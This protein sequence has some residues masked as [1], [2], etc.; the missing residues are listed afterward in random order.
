[1][2][3]FLCL[4]TACLISLF[5]A[6]QYT[7][8]L[9]GNNNNPEEPS[10]MINP[11]NPKY[12]VAG[13]NI[14]SAYYSSDTGR[15]WKG[16]QMS[17]SQGVYGDPVIICDTAGHFYFMHLSDPPGTPWVDRIVSQK[18]TNNGFSWDDGSFF[19]LNGVKVQDKQW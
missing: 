13:A 14:R 11:R 9:V 10:I 6:A 17:S 8:I 5:T 12:V 16:Y 2:K 15:T 4:F 19:G 1:M 7:N 3:A 18:S